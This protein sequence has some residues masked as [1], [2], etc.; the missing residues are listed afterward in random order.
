MKKLLFLFLFSLLFANDVKI[1][2]FKQDNNDVNLSFI[3]K[4]SV[5]DFKVYIKDGNRTIES[6]IDKNFSNSAI[7]LIDTSLS[8]KKY[9]KNIKSLIAKIT[10]KLSSNTE[11]LIAGFDRNIKIIKGF[12]EPFTK[13]TLKKLIVNGKVTELY[14]SGIEAI[15]LL[16]KQHI[17]RKILVIFSDGGAEDTAY[18]VNDLIEEAKKNNVTILSIGYNDSV[19]LQSIERPAIESWGKLWLANKNNFLDEFLLFFNNGAN[20]SFENNFITETGRKELTLLVKNSDEI[21]KKNFTIKTEIKKS[22]DMFIYITILILLVLIVFLI[23]WKKNR[24]KKTSLSIKKNKKESGILAYL[25]DDSGKK[26][27][28]VELNTSIG[29]N[30]SNDIVIEGSYISNFHADIILKNGKFFII[31]KNS[32]N[33]VSINIPISENNKINKVQLNNNDEVYLGPLKLKFV[34]KDENETN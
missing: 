12:D 28:I 22:G 30:K 21:F 3:F 11:I 24:Q 25:I 13:D 2:Q 6:R 31:D 5:R 19:R 14:K 27:P 8:M 9:S 34:I 23:Y 20:I 17:T 16:K 32:T 33:G 15:N 4:N 1:L 10:K 29:R 7:F 18:S 26:Y